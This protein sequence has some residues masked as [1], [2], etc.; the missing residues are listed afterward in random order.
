[1]HRAAAREAA[2]R[3][4]VVV[5]VEAAALGAACL[6][7]GLEAEL[8]EEVG[9][10]PQVG[11]VRTHAGEAAQRELLGDLGVLRDER[12]V[13]GAVDDELEREPLGI[14]QQHRAK[15]ALAA[16]ALRPEV[17]GLLGGDAEDD[18]VHHSV[19]GSPG[20]GAGVLEE[21]D[22]GPGA[23]ALVGVEEVVDGRVVLID[24]L[25]HEPQPERAGVELDVP[26]RVAGD[27][28]DVVDALEL[29]AVADSA[30]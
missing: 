13:A 3:R 2:L 20:R 7:A 9:A 6:P 21:G 12:L 29:H 27:A 10:L 17:E 4:R 1:M 24:C 8:E 26:R 15:S 5:D 16:C 23:A 28:R 11:R 14:V 19:A 25:L 18:A 30:R 22:V